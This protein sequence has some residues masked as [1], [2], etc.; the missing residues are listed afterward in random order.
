MKLRDL[1][2]GALFTAAAS[3]ATAGV[4]TVD[5]F[6]V[7]QGPV[8]DLTLDGVAV[9]NTLG[10]RTISANLMSQL[11]PVDNSA[12]VAAGHFE[13][14]NNIGEQTEVIV[15]WVIAP[16]MLPDATSAVFSGMI[17]AADLPHT[18]DF[19]FN[20]T[21][22]GSVAVSMFTLNE[23]F[24]FAFDPDLFNAGGTLSMVILSNILGQDLALDLLEI[25]YSV[26]TPGTL[27]LI[28][29]G[30]VGAGLSRR[31]RQA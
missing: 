13:I 24:S 27:A 23:S 28:G 31:R 18:I 1:F 26:P 14:N 4:Y 16:D 21:S 11:P 6:S 22:I 15:D 8:T 20:G 3:T 17:L 12:Q 2:V 19:L 30:L 25:T 5:D 10:N 7:D 9:S 29:L